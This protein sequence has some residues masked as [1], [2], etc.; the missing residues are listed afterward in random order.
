MADNAFPFTLGT[1]STSSALA[2]L[3][4]QEYVDA[5]PLG[6][7]TFVLVRAA[8][9]ITA[10]A[11]KIIASA[12]SGGLP[13]FVANT[14]TTANLGPAMVIPAEHTATIPSGAYFFAQV[15]GPAEVISAAAIA[16]FANVGTSTT[17]GKADDATITGASVGYALESA[18]GADEN[19]GVML[20]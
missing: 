2:S 7:R 18:A 12:Q 11:R 10:P 13:T 8:A 4:G 9:E 1:S 20:R 19:V 16:A 15:R 5:G 17:A 14:T 3:L 6:A